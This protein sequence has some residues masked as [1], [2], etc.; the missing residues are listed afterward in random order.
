MNIQI[1]IGLVVTVIWASGYAV[2]IITRGGY[3]PDLAVNAVMLTVV[4]YFFSSG[5]KKGSKR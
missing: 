3:Q 4:G 5:I 1:F 2:S